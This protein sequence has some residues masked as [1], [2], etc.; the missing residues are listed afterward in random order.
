MLGPTELRR[1]GKHDLLLPC[2]GE[3]IAGDLAAGIGRRVAIGLPEASSAASRFAAWSGVSPGSM[4]P[5]GKSQFL[6]ARRISI[7]QPSAVRRTGTM[8]AETKGTVT[9]DE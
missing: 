9:S 5:L 1:D 2:F 3:V 7:R 6:Y 8:P 4:K